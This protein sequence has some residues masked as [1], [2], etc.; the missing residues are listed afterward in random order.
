MLGVQWETR[1][2]SL[3]EPYQTLWQPLFQKLKHKGADQKCN[4]IHSLSI[5]KIECNVAN[6]RGEFKER[7][8][9]VSDWAGKIGDGINGYGE[10]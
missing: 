3:H 7:G 10:Q 4:A 5:T 9:A 2:V 1:S 8:I 6:L